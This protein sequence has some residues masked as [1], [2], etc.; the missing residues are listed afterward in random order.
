MIT[1]RELVDRHVLCNQNSVVE[2][3]LRTDESLIDNICNLDNEVLEWWL[4]TDWLA[5]Q[6]AEQGETIIDDYGCYWWGRQTSGQAI[7][8]DAVM[9]SI[10]ENFQ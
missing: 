1:E 5:E 8:M 4:V 10:C 6:L 2:H 3:L 9:T 7:C